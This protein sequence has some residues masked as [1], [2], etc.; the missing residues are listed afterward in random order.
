MKK[1]YTIWQSLQQKGY[2]RHFKCPDYPG[3]TGSE[4][5]LTYK[6]IE[7]RIFFVE[8]KNQ[9]GQTTYL[10]FKDETEALYAWGKIN[11]KI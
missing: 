11:G 4:K 5:R 1:K 2:F 6:H 9:L 3:L 10:E 8:C 7:T